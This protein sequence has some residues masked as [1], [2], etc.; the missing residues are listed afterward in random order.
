M[1]YEIFKKIDGF[2]TYECSNMGNI[3]TFNW[4][5]QGSERVMKPAP[6]NGGYLRTMLK[7]DSDGKFCTIKVHRIIALT[8]IDNP[9]NKATVNHKNGI[10]SD[11]RV[12]NLE[13]NTISENI[14]HAY[15]NNYMTQKGECNSNATLSDSEVLE[16][17]ENYQYGR[18]SRHDGGL[19]KLQIAEKYNT[20]F[21]VIKRIIQGKTWKHLL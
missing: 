11:N 21:T 10:K 9:E 7:R 3:K 13:W 20:T 14:L 1:R 5:N 8:F 15:K 2:S 16:I 4:K 18:K 17:R 6:D 12:S 19:T